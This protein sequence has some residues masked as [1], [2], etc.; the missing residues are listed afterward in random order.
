MHMAEIRPLVRLLHQRGTHWIF[1]NINPLLGV[2]L[3]IPQAMMETAVLELAGVGTR[4]GEPVFS[5][6]DPAF[7]G[8]P[9][10][11]R[12]AEEM[13]VIGNQQVIA[14]E[15]YGGRVFPDAVQDTLHGV[16]RQPA[17]PP[18]RADGEEN[19]VRSARGS[20]TTATSAR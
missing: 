19:P 18:E 4:L 13:L 16:L 17:L 15:P 7:D 20:A 2:A 9:Q 3:A 12:R 5:E 14:D 11:L 6:S 1:P 8:E 10:V